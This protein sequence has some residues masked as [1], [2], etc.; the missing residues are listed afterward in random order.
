MD[1]LSINNWQPD[2]RPRE[3]MMAKG[4]GALSNAELLAILIGSGSARESAVDLVRRV[5]ASRGDSLRS[6]GQMTIGELMDFNGIGEAKAI[7][8][9]AACELGKRRQAEEARQRIDLSSAQSIFEYLQPK[10]QDLPT[11][12]AWIVLLNQNF[13]LIGDAIRLSQGGLTETAVDVRIIVKHAILNNA[14][15]VVLAHNHPSNNASPSGQDD[16]ITRQVADALKLMRLH[17]ADHIIVTEG[18]YYSY[19]EHGKI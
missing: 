14:T 8:L 18:K 7:T 11:E 16:R 5:M 4:P 9:L 19:M 6:L 13:K 10:M 1:K 3:K 17:L 12:E 15:V 2:D